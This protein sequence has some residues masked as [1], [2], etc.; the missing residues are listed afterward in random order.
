MKYGDVRLGGV[1]ALINSVGGEAGLQLILQGKT[2][3]EDLVG[4]PETAQKLRFLKGLPE[5][6]DLRDFLR[7]WGKY[8]HN[9]FSVDFGRFVD[10]SLNICLSAL[11]ESK[12]LHP[13]NARD[14]LVQ[15][16]DL[17]NRVIAYEAASGNKGL[18]QI[19]GMLGRAFDILVNPDG[20]TPLILVM[21]VRGMYGYFTA[22]Q[23]NVDRINKT[24]E[25]E[26]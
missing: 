7:G 15:A 24:L 26:Q 6:L 13:A 14:L 10:R 19:K 18:G 9:M 5:L 1:E 22:V 21:H 11:E 23:E 3:L 4:G 2:K 12:S 8:H 20:S 16:G 25:E 17:K